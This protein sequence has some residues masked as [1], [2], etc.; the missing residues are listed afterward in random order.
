MS[1]HANA[2]IS[3]IASPAL[4]RTSASLTLASGE[5]ANF[6]S[7]VPF[8]ARIGS[9][10]STHEDVRV[11]AR[12]GDTLTITRAQNDTT[13]A[14]WPIGTPV[15]LLA[16]PDSGDLWGVGAMVA[17]TSGA[18]GP[19]LLHANAAQ[20]VATAG[21]IATAGLSVSRVN[22]SAGSATGVILAAGT[23]DGQVCIVENDH[24]TNTVTFAAA[25]TSNVADGASDAIAALRAATF[26]WNATTSRWYRAA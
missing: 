10:I 26:V 16:S 11:T 12:S 23:V 22:P 15:S 17:L 8:I 18:S 4:T 25:A 1:D 5:G 14:A 3:T 6:P 19:V 21:T 7:R 24:A 2:A 9:P 13:A 20:T